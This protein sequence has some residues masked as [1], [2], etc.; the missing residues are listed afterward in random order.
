VKFSD[1][2][3]PA[4]RESQVQREVALAGKEALS[5]AEVRRLDH[6]S[7]SVREGRTR[8]IAFMAVEPPRI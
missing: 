6:E 8:Y 1:L 7:S 4:K 3:I 5:C 2:R